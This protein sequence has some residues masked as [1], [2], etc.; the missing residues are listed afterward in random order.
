MSAVHAFPDNLLTHKILSHRAFANIFLLYSL[1]ERVHHLFVLAL[2]WKE[3]NRYVDII[4]IFRPERRRMHQGQTLE[5]IL[6]CSLYEL[7]GPKTESIG[8]QRSM[9]GP[10]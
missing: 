5:K 3:S 4:R 6:V 2:A 9:A 1:P 8:L 7:L 10:I